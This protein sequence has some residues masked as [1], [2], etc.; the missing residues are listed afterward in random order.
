MSEHDAACTIDAEVPVPP[1]HELPASAERI[2]QE[3]VDERLHAWCEL[4]LVDEQTWAI[5]G[6]IAY[7]GEVILAEFEHREDAQ[8]ALEQLAARS[9][10]I[11]TR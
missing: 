7:E 9:P 11:V 6:S 1:R 10:G 8:L 2:V 4:V 5:L 3:L